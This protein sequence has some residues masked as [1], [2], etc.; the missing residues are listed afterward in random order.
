MHEYPEVA[1]VG[2]DAQVEGAGVRTGIRKDRLL[3]GGA[4]EDAGLGML[5]QE[6]LEAQEGFVLQHPVG[7]NLRGESLGR[8][9][10]RGLGGG[11]IGLFKQEKIA[12]ILLFPAQGLE[13][14]VGVVI[15]LADDHLQRFPAAFRL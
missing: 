6:A 12:R 8:Q 5:L 2:L 7:G 15:G 1:A 9:H 14:L 3:G 13:F 10:Q 11:P 4:V